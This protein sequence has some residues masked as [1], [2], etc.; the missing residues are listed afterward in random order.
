M[1]VQLDRR[2]ALVAALA[3]SPLFVVP[4]RAALAA[5]KYDGPPVLYKTSS[6]ILF[7]DTDFGEDIPRTMKLADVFAQEAV[8]PG[9]ETNPSG[10]KVIL[11]YR[12][13]HAQP[14]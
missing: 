2:T 10:T 1:R 6:G 13:L 7:Y 9:S 8:D 11:N 14:I 4:P 12:V 3:S 5:V